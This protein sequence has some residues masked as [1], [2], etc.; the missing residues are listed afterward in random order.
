MAKEMGKRLGKCA[1]LQR[2]VQAM[3]SPPPSFSEFIGVYN[4]DA[5][6]WGELTYWIGAR[7]GTRHCSLC[8]ITHGLFTPRAEWRECASSLEIPFT[9]FHINDAPPDV[10]QA[11]SGNYPIVL[12]RTQT[13]LQ[14][15]LTDAELKQC[16]GSPQALFGKL[17]N[18]L[19]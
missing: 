19:Q 2:S 17:Q 5:T 10:T 4:A 15:L 9:T 16:A 11:A 18:L 13:G 7:L 8:D 12:G 14:V 6:L 1:L 3:N